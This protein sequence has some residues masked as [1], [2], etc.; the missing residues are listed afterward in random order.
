[1]RRRVPVQNLRGS[2]L[3][4]LEVQLQDLLRRPMGQIALANVLDVITLAETEGRP[5]SLERS[6]QLFVERIAANIADLP[7]GAPFEELLAELSEM[8]GDRVPHRFRE[9]LQQESERSDRDGERIGEL[10]EKWAEKEPRPFELG[11]QRAKVTRAVSVAQPAGDERPRRRVGSGS[12][13]ASTGRERVVTEDDRERQSWIAE[14]VLE[15]V[16]GAGERGLG[17]QVLIAGVRHRARERYPTITPS[18]I[19]TVLKALKES[20]RVRYS[21]GRWSAPARW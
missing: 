20:G 5:R 13:P 15:R 7:R 18:E 21:A 3:T 8:E 9:I 4:L 17:E 10:L 1:M 6:L 16:A 19:T 2:D 14:T 12:R 11:Q